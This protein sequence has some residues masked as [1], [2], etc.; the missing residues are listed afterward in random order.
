MSILAIVAILV[1]GL[2]AFVWSTRGFYNALIHM[3][4]T[5]IAG[6][7][8][9]AV[10][11]PASYFL[12]SA[13]G[14]GSMGT[15]LESCAWGL[16][17]AVPFGVSL[18]VLRGI[19]DSTLRGNILVTTAVNYAG[20]GVCGLIIGTIT[21]GILIISVSNLRVASEFM[22]YQPYRYDNNGNLVRQDRLIFPVDEITAGVYNALSERA[23]AS[24]EPLARWHPDASQEGGAMRVSYNEGAARNTIR[25]NEVTLESRFTVNADSLKQLLSD[26]LPGGGNEQKA[27]D[28]Q[29]QTFDP[30][31]RIEGFVLKFGP[32]AGEKSGKV[33]MGAGQIRLL[34]ADQTDENRQLYFPITISSQAEAPPVQA[35]PSGIAPP[36]NPKPL[37]SRWR[38]DG[39]DVFISSVGG[40]AETRFAFE[41]VVPK[42]Y[43]PVALY[44]RGTRIDLRSKS[45]DDTFTP[46]ARDAFVLGGLVKGASVGQIDTSQVVQ[47]KRDSSANNAIPGLRVGESIGWTIQLGLHQGLQ[48][49]ENDDSKFR[50][51]VRGGEVTWSKQDVMKMR[52]GGME[53]PLRVEKFVVEPD[54]TLVHLTVSGVDLKASPASLLGPVAKDQDRSLPPLLVDTNGNVFPVVGFQ[55]ED[56][57]KVMLRYTPDRP[58][59][60]IDELPSLTRSRPDQQLTLIFRVSKGTAV[61]Y[62]GIGSKA[63]V[64]YVPPAEAK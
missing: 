48:I 47:V 10:W 7:I 51:M 36:Q 9:F 44:V 33:I 17:L 25:P 38:Y 62:F 52:T 34:V 42:K 6:A 2:V 53:K 59:T 61:Q 16:G 19:T 60:K 64:E 29:G 39:R 32:S 49:D 23:F 20:G 15:I 1:A 22:G 41:F 46:A 27:L 63:I 24:A 43:N 26:S 14:K 21:S 58:V 56:E 37:F 13:M 35:D 31:S 5:L 30:A 11:E 45:A 57:V 55:Y 40:G 28:A 18:A 4:C 54:T 12:L 50:N 3:L 8:A